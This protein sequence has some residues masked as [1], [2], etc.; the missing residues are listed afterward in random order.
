MKIFN[1]KLWTGLFLFGIGLQPIF[2]QTEEVLEDITIE[3]VSI[4]DQLMQTEQG[5]M[6]LLIGGLLATLIVLLIVLT[7]LMVKTADIILN[8]R[9]AEKGEVRLSFYQQFKQR[10]ITGKLRPVD[11]QGDMMLDHDYDGIK[12]M[13]Y[14]MPPWL[15]YVFL[16]TFLFA[17]F[18]I[19]AFLIFDIVPDQQTEYQQQIEEAA[20]LA[21]ARAKAG[22]VAISAETAEFSDEQSVIEAGSAIY[23]KNCA[24]CHA[25]DG[26]G[27][28]GPNLTDEYW[29]HGND[30]SGVFTTV[31]EGVPAKGMIPWKGN[32]SPKEI[33]DVSNYVLSLVGTTPASPKEP[34]GEIRKQEMAEERI[35]E[36]V[37]ELP[38]VKEV[39]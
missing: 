28:V 10:W 9:A 1:K 25:N 12:E 16:G 6:L 15:S 11:Q 7:I 20:L 34:Q 2:A 33:Q 17:V 26:G 39:E 24:V 30:I 36:K 23:Q 4:W 37:E 14:G 22:M 18:Y 5:R 35:E 31:S 27:G 13:D 19:P 21:E 29:L 8:K 32:L 38:E 3:K